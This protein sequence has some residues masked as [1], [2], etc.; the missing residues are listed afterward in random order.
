MLAD[1]AARLVDF[2]EVRLGEMD[3][4]G[5]DYVILSQTGPG[6]QAEPDAAVA[7]RRAREN[8]DFLVQQVAATDALWR[9][10]HHTH[11]RS[12]VAAAELERCVRQLGFKGALI[13]GHTNG[14]YYDG[15]AYDPFWEK[16]QELDAPVYLHP[17]D[18]HVVPQAYS[19]TP[20]W[21]AH[22]GAGASRPPPTRCACCSAACS[23]AI[24]ASS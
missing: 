2:D 24:P 3:R 15:R 14:V 11:A 22:A 9:L 21:S 23:T 13:N 4:G 7:L 1:L 6:V 16:V 19:A 12:R 8:N 5:I 17:S 18:P 20:S 10:R